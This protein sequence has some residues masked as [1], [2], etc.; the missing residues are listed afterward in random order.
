MRHFE[1]V[2]I[3]KFYIKPEN[4]W[5]CYQRLI[6]EIVCKRSVDIQ[7]VLSDRSQ[8]CDVFKDRSSDSNSRRV[9]KCINL[10]R[11]KICLAIDQMSEIQHVEDKSNDWHSRAASR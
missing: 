9:Y 2:G 10:V 6:L 5:K 3:I 7:E 8:L 1:I 11:F 4:A